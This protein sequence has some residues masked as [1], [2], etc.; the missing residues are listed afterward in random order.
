MCHQSV[1]LIAREIEAQGIATICLSSAYSI[2]AAVNPPRAVYLDFP[3]GHTSGKAHDKALQRR[4]MI[5]TLQALESI[6][7]P[8]Q[9]V[10]LEHQWHTDDG[11]KDRV[12]RPQSDSGNHSDDRIERVSEPQYQTDDD[13]TQ[14]NAAMRTDGCPTCVWL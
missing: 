10:E 6:Q 2:T 9:I 12:M 13:A 14:A 3:L 7:S 1:G 5:Q 11:W 4:I 8:G